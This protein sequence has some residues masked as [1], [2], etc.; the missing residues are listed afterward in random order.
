MLLGGGGDR[1]IPADYIRVGLTGDS[2]VLTED[3]TVAI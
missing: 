1:L 2:G 3:Q